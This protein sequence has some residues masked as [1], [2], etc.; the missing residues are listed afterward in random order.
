ME[1][2]EKAPGWLTTEITYFL[3][4]LGNSKEVRNYRPIM[5]LTTMQKTQRGITAERISKHLEEKNWPP[6]EQKWC[7]PGSKG[8]KAQ[9]VIS[10]A[11]YGTAREETII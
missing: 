7:H 1:E 10:E 8:C 11:I 2:S 4:K 6:A 9:P 5:C 3:P